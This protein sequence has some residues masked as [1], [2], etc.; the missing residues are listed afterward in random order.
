M[1]TQLGIAVAPELVEA[2]HSLDQPLV[3]V[4]NDDLTQLVP[5]TDFSGAAGASLPA[6]FDTVHQYAKSTYPSPRYII[7]PSEDSGNY[8]F[9]LFIPDDA[10]IRQKMLYALTKNTLLLSLGLGKFPKNKTFAW[11]DLEEL[12]HQYYQRSIGD[13]DTAGVMTEDERV[14][15]TINRMENLGVG[16]RQLASM[17]TQDNLLYPFELS[18]ELAFAD[19]NKQGQVVVFRIDSDREQLALQGSKSAVTP[20]SLVSVLEAHT[21]DDVQP[22]YAIYQYAD[23]NT[24][25]IYSCPLGSKVKQRMLYASFKLGLINHLK[26]Q[27]IEITKNIEV[28]DLDELETTQFNPVSETVKDEN[29]VGLKFNKPR[30]PRRR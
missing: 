2:F 25:F 15:S 30:G 22:Q 20:E 6:H 26:Q 29:K 17:G 11:T 23:G 9:I 10:H 14:V 7:I 21:S 13:N 16:N 3:V 5:D 18:L 4:V 12:T 24:A 19:F 8:I 1:S 28:G 27:G